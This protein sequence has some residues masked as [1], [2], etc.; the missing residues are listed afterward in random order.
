MTGFTRQV[1]GTTKKD[2]ARQEKLLSG[3]LQTIEIADEQKAPTIETP[4]VQEGASE[5]LKLK[6]KQK[7]RA[8]T[9]F[10]G[11]ILGDDAPTSITAAG[12]L[13]KANLGS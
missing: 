7:G 6:K 9:I 4:A 13:M 3:G 1:T 2:I 10:S 8:S 11:R 5:T 12:Q